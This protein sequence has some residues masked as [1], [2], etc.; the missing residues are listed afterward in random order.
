MTTNL[1]SRLRE[2]DRYI[3]AATE[4]RHKQM[5]RNFQQHNEYEQRGDLE[6]LLA[7]YTDDAEFHVYGA[8]FGPDRELHL[9]GKAALRERY[10]GM[11]A[12]YVSR[13]GDPE[14]VLE[15]LITSDW[16]IAGFFRS[17]FEVPGTV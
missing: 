16:G 11:F 1:E 6:R 9:A 15:Q 4:P 17:S 12:N 13:S 8:V 10:K 5:I 7:L 14:A 2:F 3:E